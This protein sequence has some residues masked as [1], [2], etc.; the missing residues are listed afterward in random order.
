MKIKDNNIRRNGLARSVARL[1]ALQA[2]YQIEFLGSQAVEI[3]AEFSKYRIGVE[4]DG[5]SF[6]NTDFDHFN[7]LVTSV[8][9]E[10]ERL[11]G[12]IS[13]VLNPDWKVGR[14]GYLK[15]SLLR[16]ALIELTDRL[17]IPARV[18]IDEYI[19]LARAFFYENESAFVNAALDRLARQF[20]RTEIGSIDEVDDNV[21][22][23]PRI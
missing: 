9:Q 11:D 5:D 21:R 12:H 4:I 17:D 14:L 23:S 15:L 18:I 13:G 22:I 2:L 19:D 3:V 20:R 8:A 16:A 1:N 7:W 10:K 6:A